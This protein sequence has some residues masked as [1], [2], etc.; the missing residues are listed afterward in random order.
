MLPCKN[1]VLAAFAAVGG[2]A[3]YL[4]GPWDALL[5][6][7]LAAI[8]LDYLTG[9]AV[10]A[11][12]RTLSSAVGWRGLLKKAVILLIVCLGTL[13][14]RLLEDSNGAVRAAVCLFYIANEG[15]SVL[16]NA[17]ALGLPLP[18]TLK[19]ALARLQPPA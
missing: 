5:V 3:A 14:D 2:I 10:A 15:L 12:Q 16:E 6:A 11:V 9:V 7:L 19:R 18:E 13:L 1:A 8:V 17:G 4:F